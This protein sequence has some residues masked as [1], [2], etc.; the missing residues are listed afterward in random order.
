MK[1]QK[2][3]SRV[4]KIMMSSRGDGYVSEIFKFAIIMALILSFVV[5]PDPFI[6][7]LNLNHM[8]TS[9]VRAVETTGEIN[10]DV[11]QMIEEYKAETGLNPTIKWEG[12][13]VNV[14]TSQRIQIRQRFSLT[15]T[16]NVVITIAE[17]SFTGPINIVIPISKKVN[18]MCEVYWKPGQI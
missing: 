15:L 7:K 11:Y 18:G 2:Y 12:N 13:F 6:K 9:I 4:M 5:L 10:D 8:T 16:D 14:G 1:K 3:I 17:P